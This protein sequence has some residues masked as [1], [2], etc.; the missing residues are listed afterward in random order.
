[1]FQA[2]LKESLQSVESHKAHIELMRNERDQLVDSTSFLYE[3]LEAAKAEHSRCQRDRNTLE[4]KLNQELHSS[5]FQDDIIQ[6]EKLK[7]VNNT[8]NTT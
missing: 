1:M 2:K 6:L 7:E 3:E 8:I 5:L 4:Q